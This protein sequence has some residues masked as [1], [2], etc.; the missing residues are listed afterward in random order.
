MN[1]LHFINTERGWAVGDKGT[2]LRTVNGGASWG[3]GISN[4]KEDLL[5]VYF[6]NA[7]LGFAVGANGVILRSDSAA[8]IGKY[9]TPQARLAG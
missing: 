2:V 7:K 3:K 9:W 5:G 6:I 4:A 8:R 1:S